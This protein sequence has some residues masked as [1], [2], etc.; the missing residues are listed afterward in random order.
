MKIK[1]LNLKTKKQEEISDKNII[2][3]LYYNTHKIVNPTPDISNYISNIEGKIPLYDIYTYNLYLIQPDNLYYR[4]TYNHYRFPTKR[5]LDSLNKEISELKSEDIIT[6]RRIKKYKLMIDFLNNYNLKILEDTFY[7][8]MYKNSPELGKNL[9]FCKRKSF[10]KY[11]HNSKPYYS[12]IE[13][14][15]LARNMGKK[16][17]PETLSEDDIN[18]LCDYV[19]S[20]DITADV[21][22]EHQKHIVSKNLL[23]LIQYY[24][25]TGSANLNAYLRNPN[26]IQNNTFDEMITNLTNL[27]LSAPAFDNDYTLYRFIK[28]DNYLQ[29]L[30]IGDTYTENSFMS[31]TRDPFYR[32]DT[33]SFGFILLKISI[34]KNT[35]GVALCL[36]GCSHFPE[37][38]EIIFPPGSQFKLTARD[39]GIT[40]YHTDLNYTSQIQTKYEFKWIGYKDLK[41]KDRQKDNLPLIDFLDTK[42]TTTITLTERIKNFRKLLSDTSRALTKIGDKEFTIIGETYNSVSAYKKFFA[43]TTNNGYSIYSIYDNYLLFMIEIGTVNDIDEM[44]INFYV[45]YNTLNIKEIINMHDLVKFFSEVAYYFAISR[46]IIYAEYKPCAIFSGL[47]TNQRL[48]NTDDNTDN[49]LESDIDMSTLIG[50]YCYDFYLYLK[51]KQKRFFDDKILELELTPKFSYYDLDYLRTININNF[52]DKSDDELY[53]IYDKYYS[54]EFPK[55]KLA[56][57]LVWI[58]ENKCYL[59][60]KFINKLRKIYKI[61]PFKRDMYVLDPITY[62]YNRGFVTAYNSYYSSDITERELNIIR[63]DEYK[64]NNLMV[65]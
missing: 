55:T 36:E 27:C 44:H 16:V 47:I 4:V 21:L 23:G 64:R 46:V 13:I 35:P 34:P 40:Y 22:L 45:K 6:T 2:D 54:I 24:T 62:L 50:N 25:I 7:R 5:L 52:F 48:S 58:I 20:N 39:E 43:I 33:Y 38:Q 28:N 42:P 49:D 1:L 53:Q 18:K 29:H 8:T 32:S 3:A 12:R 63:T 51:N 61:K 65:R 57:Y 11:I 14:I 19:S 26:S 30:K 17:N 60:D 37:E 31:T 56:D 9:L 15:N 41:Q 10:N 59:T